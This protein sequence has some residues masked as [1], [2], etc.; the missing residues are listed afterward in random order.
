MISES[1]LVTTTLCVAAISVIVI[2]VISV[3]LLTRRRSRY[4][5]TNLQAAT[6]HQEKLR[7]TE[8]KPVSSFK[9]AAG[10][11]GLKKSP[12]PMQSPENIDIDSTACKEIQPKNDRMEAS[13][14]ECVTESNEQK[15]SA[16]DWK[17][18]EG[19]EED[20]EIA[21]EMRA[22]EKGSSCGKLRYRLI[23]DFEKNALTVH[24]ISASE[25]IPK[26]NCR[27]REK[28][29]LDPYVK[30]QLLP[31]KQHKIKTR[32]VRNTAD[33]VYDEDFVF[34]GINYNQLQNTTLHFAVI[35]FD[36]FLR[37]KI[38]GEALCPL[39]SLNLKESNKAIDIN[40]D[41]VNRSLK[42]QNVKLRGEVLVSLCFRQAT[43]KI[44]VAVLK[45]QNLPTFDLTGYA[46]P[47]VKIYLLINGIKIAKKKTHVKKR[48]VSPVYNEAFIFDL[49]EPSSAV[50]DKISVE[51]LVMDWDRIT[52]NEVMGRVEIGPRAS[53][54]LGQSH[55][56][57]AKSNPWKQIAHWHQLKP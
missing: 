38:I 33:P 37:D 26:S 31:E 35:A 24:I 51:I 43:N 8:V 27:W 45:A 55:W 12:S 30:L 47:Y 17:E 49:P 4:R 11:G 16:I 29:M 36:R 18:D 21:Y 15:Y 5:Y 40:I 48:T 3:C 13:L 20:I 6:F 2:I 41:L 34:Y 42:F 1:N 54:A 56:E 53:S 39:N 19:V 22:D 14:S 57:E 44:C 52:K 25:L 50:T 10:P 23:Y 7:A 9:N 46:D 32:V 28:V